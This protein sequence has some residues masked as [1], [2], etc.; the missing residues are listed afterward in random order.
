MQP[1][2]PTGLSAWEDPDLGAT[3]G[4]KSRSS[5]LGWRAGNLTYDEP[6]LP[7]AASHVRRSAIFPQCGKA[8]FVRELARIQ[9][10]WRSSRFSPQPNKGSVAWEES[11]SFL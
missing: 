11:G 8:G 9:G 3:R 4:E 5:G 1:A 2:M 10:L 6:W 7:S